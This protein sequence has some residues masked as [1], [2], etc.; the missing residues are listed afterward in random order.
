MCPP[1]DNPT[2]DDYARYRESLHS[3]KLSRST[4][5]QYGYSAKAYHEMIGEPIKFKRIAPNNQIP[6]YFT[7]DDID[8][9]FSVISN[10]KHLA[11][12]QT[13]F[14]SCLRANE[15]CQLNDDDLDL[16][17]LTLR[18]SG[19]GGYDGLACNNSHIQER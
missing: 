14:Y 7:D 3:W 11:M 17:C 15:L 18:V 19:K 13:L 4:L 1:Q 10:I 12:L 8:K 2:S 5:N 9:I 6:F 16:N